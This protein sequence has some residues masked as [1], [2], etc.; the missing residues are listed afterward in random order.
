MGTRRL[1]FALLAA[2]PAPVGAAEKD[3]LGDPLP[4]GARAR[5][6]TTRMRNHGGWSDAALTPDGRH[7]LVHDGVGGLKQVEVATGLAA[8]PGV[9]YPVKFRYTSWLP[10]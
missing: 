8:G 9:K 10:S 5:L 6:G 1:V 3:T 4:V 2:V 7:I